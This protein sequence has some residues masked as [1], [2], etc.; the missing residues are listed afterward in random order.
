MDIRATIFDLDGVL[1]DTAEYHYQGWKRLAE[2]EGIPFTRE[3]NEALRGVS[4]RQSL[5]LLL[6]GRPI[7]EDQAQ[8]W[9]ARKND[10]YNE[11]IKQISPADLLPGAADLLAE[12][13][14]AGLKVAVASASRNART[15]LDGLQ[16]GGQIDAL[17]DGHSVA[18]TKPAPDLF[19]HAAAQLGVPPSQCLV[20]EDA[21]AGIEAAQA[22]GMRALALGPA[23]RFAEVRP[24]AIL[25]SLEGETWQQI[26]AALEAGHAGATIWTITEDE[27]PIRDA[28]ADLH[29]VHRQETVFTIGNGYLGTRG[30]FEEGI[31]GDWAGT[32]IHGLFDDAPVVYSELVNAPN[33][34]DC[35]LFVEGQRFT[36]EQGQV[37]AYKRTLDL[38]DGVLTRT[39][40]WRSPDGRTLELHIERWASMAEPGLCVL[41]Y[42]VTALDFEGQIEIR[43]GLDG[44]VANPVPGT[45]L[46]LTHWRTLDQ[47]HPSA[48]SAFLHLRTSASGMALGAAMHLSIEGVDQVTYRPRD[49]HRQPGVSAQFR[50]APGQTAVARKLVTYSTTSAAQVGAQFIAP[51]SAAQDTLAASTAAGYAALLRAHRA[52]W[53]DLWRDCDIMIE[54]D[55]RAQQ[56]VRYNIFQL[57]IAAPHYTDR[58]S[59]PAKTLSGFGYRGHVFWDTEIFIVPFFTWTRPEIARNLL[60]YRYHTLAGAREKARKSAYEGAMFAWE[61]AATGHETTPRWGM[62]ASGELVRIWCGDIE[63]HISADVAYAVWQYWQVTGDDDFMRDYGAEILLDT[64][65]FW[66]S[67]AEYNAELK[68]YEINDVIGPDEYHEHVNNNAYTNRLVQWHLETALGVL[69]WLKEHYPDKAAD[70][71]E[72]LK[73]SDERLAHVFDVRRRLYIPYDRA[74]G[75]MEQFEGFFNLEE[76]DW[77]ALEP[78]T[79]SVPDL[80]GLERVQRV[81]AIKQADVLMLIYLLRHEF[82]DKALRANWDYYA[83]RTDH[84][85]GSSLSPAIHAIL[86]CELGDA[87]AA[88][89]HFLRAALV[90]LQDL[91]KNTRDGIHAASAGG[92]W[93]AVVMGFAGMRLGPD[94]PVFTARFP[95]GWRRLRFSV[96]YR[97]RTF[98]V[99]LTVNS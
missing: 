96:R 53:A 49:C 36:L 24:D 7:S 19:L 5:D 3:D 10:Y 81:Q 64:A 85:Y 63:H 50:L 23:Q 15:V 71:S 84:T 70:L 43:A 27:P 79:K 65:V 35:Q 61:S 39:V 99:N 62:T 20:V 32:L 9:M 4:R 83:A 17:S 92:V 21:A 18:N 6:K 89:E 41:H 87:G 95:Q 97:G 45:E 93:Q 52:R 37:L 38:R 86:A 91:R 34:L 33:W 60:M 72:R 48:Q 2:E 98:P 82:D 12:L 44:T 40:R 8:A 66:A 88:Y 31:S 1:T 59:I 13:R 54:G 22:A 11:S 80:I 46:G 51:F 74:T 56:A 25:R 68:R 94:G 75:L 42:G 14:S 55:D 30:T 16:I 76:L 26:I 28:P 67:R 90:D 73:L 57:L 78:R 77:Q 69:G 47:G 29:R 58:A